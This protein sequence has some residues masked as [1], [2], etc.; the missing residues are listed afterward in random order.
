MIPQLYD[1][2]KKTVQKIMEA[3]DF[4]VLTRNTWSSRGTDS[5]IS[6]TAHFIIDK[7]TS[8]HC[9]LQASKFNKRH[10]GDNIATM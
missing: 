4:V 2:W 5:A 1:S 7:F 8:D 10:T 9:L 3:Q 6:F